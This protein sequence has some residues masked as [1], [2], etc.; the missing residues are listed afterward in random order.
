MR[1]QLGGRYTECGINGGPRAGSSTSL[2]SL[3]KIISVHTFTTGKDKPTED[4]S[5]Q[6]T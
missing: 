2:I 6:S 1:V 4:D 5:Y 3:W